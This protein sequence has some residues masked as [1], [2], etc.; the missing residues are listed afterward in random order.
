[1]LILCHYYFCFVWLHL[2]LPEAPSNLKAYNVWGNVI[3]LGWTPGYSGRAVIL[4]YQIQYNNATDYQQDPSRAIWRDI[5]NITKI[6]ENPANITYLKPNSIYR[7]R[8]RAYNSVGPSA[9]W[10]NISGDFSTGEGGER[11]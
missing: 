10:S 7:F 2:E 4:R 6:L 11:E 9:K 5:M 1:M 8:M 3:A